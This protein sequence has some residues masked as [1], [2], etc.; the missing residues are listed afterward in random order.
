MLYLNFVLTWKLEFIDLKEWGLQKML[1]LCE[2]KKETQLI[3]SFSSLSYKC[4]FCP[5]FLQ[6]ERQDLD[7]VEERNAQVQL[8][9]A[10]VHLHWSTWYLFLTNSTD[11][12]CKD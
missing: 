6:G 2:Y 1:C 11:K 8:E 9:K 10:K 4:A 7:A 3:S 12:K 5:W